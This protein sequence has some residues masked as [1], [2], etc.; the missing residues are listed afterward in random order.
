MKG[1]GAR[2]GKRDGEYVGEKKDCYEKS[3]RDAKILVMSTKVPL[4]YRSDST[5]N[6][7]LDLHFQVASKLHNLKIDTIYHNYS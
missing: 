1:K 3:G 7:L 4:S 6:T 5:R 2:E